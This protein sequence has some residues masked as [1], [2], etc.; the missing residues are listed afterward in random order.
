MKVAVMGTG[1]IGGYVGARLAD[2]GAE[3]SLVARGAHLQE[4]REHGLKVTSPNGDLH[5][6]PVQ[7]SDDPGDIGPVDIVL[8]AVK[9]YDLTTAA[10]AIR[11]MVGPDTL[12]VFLQ[13]GVDAEAVLTEAFGRKRVAGGVALING[14][15]A[16]PGVIE[17]RALNALIVGTLDGG[18]DPRLDRLVA[19][20]SESGIETTLSPDIRREIWRKFLLLAPMASLSAMTRVALGAIRD[21]AETWALAE[22]GMWEVAAVANTEGVAITAD[23]V[24]EALEF[25]GSMPETWQASTL[26]DLQ[27]GRRLEV[28]WLAGA[29]CR[30]GRNHGIATPFHQVALGALMPHAAGNV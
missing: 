29:V 27:Q 26:I 4:I 20:A 21:N 22:M 7:A 1:A 10:E 25:V 12:V 18:A 28:E 6:R 15:L 30:I 17:H 13:N 14:A 19:L 3:V 11:P 8:F 23:D 9:L 2:A 5:I 24:R 16:A